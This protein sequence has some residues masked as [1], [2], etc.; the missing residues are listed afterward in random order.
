MKVWDFEVD[1][2]DLN[3]IKS[4]LSNLIE[5]YD[6]LIMNDGVALRFSLAKWTV[7]K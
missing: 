2:E 1:L 4:V 7:I 3:S 5:K 6:S